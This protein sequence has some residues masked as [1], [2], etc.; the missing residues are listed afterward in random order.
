MKMG[1]LG[2]DIFFVISGFLLTLPW[3]NSRREQRFI[4]FVKNFYARRVLRIVPAYYV[5]LLVIIY[6][7]LFGLQKLPSTTNVVSHILFVNDFLDQPIIRGVFWTLS[8]EMCFYLTLPF[9]MWIRKPKRWWMALT[10]MAF[11]AIAFRLFLIYSHHPL[12]NQG[13]ASHF[14]NVRYIHTL[15]GRFDEFAVGMACA[16][17]YQHKKI[18]TDAGNRLFAIG[19][20]LMLIIINVYGRRGDILMEAP[21]LYLAL[22]T[23]ASIAT[24]FIIS[25]AVVRG[26]APN[27]L[28][29]AS[30]MIFVGTI[31]YS[32]YLWH[33]VILDALY[34]SE[35]LSRV[36]GV[37]R[38]SH[39]FLYSLPPILLISLVSYWWIEKPFLEIRHRIG[40]RSTPTFLQRWPLATLAAA[41]LFIFTVTLLLNL[42]VRGT[43]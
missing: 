30:T 3:L 36:E 12:F 14:N 27:R 42:L 37:T 32:V 5:T 19:L 28:L 1:F 29:G 20:A 35:L 2:V 40:D 38:L 8:V 34:R 31:S 18:P 6:L 13:D 21:L 26:S 10:A 7:S 17:L 25:G 41:G 23:I 24:G 15:A 39:A 33:T 4:P 22:P 9:I 43:P 16:W 11:G